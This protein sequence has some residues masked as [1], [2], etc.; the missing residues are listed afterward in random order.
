[1]LLLMVK[2][3]FLHQVGFLMNLKQ[4]LEEI[5]FIGYKL[6]RENNWFPTAKQLENK[7]NQLKKKI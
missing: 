3:F 7:L 5:K 2:L 4:L 6:Q 1:M